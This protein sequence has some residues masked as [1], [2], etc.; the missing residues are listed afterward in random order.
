MAGF[1]GQVFR[2]T[3]EMAKVFGKKDIVYSTRKEQL[4]VSKLL[5]QKIKLATQLGAE[6]TAEQLRQ[7][8][9]ELRELVDRNDAVD[10]AALLVEAE[11]IH[12]DVAEFVRKYT[13]R[14]DGGTVVGP[15]A[16]KSIARILS[17]KMNELAPVGETYI[18]FWKR[19]GQTYALKTKKTRIPWVTYDKKKLWQDYRP[20]VQQEIRFYDPKS[21]RY[22]RNVYQMDTPDGKVY[23][24]ADIGDTRRGLG[25]NG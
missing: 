10:G 6:D 15:E 19:V 4:A 12:P 1:Q 18:D 3:E 23:G 9:L 20:K 25:V 13:S 8:K 16:F 14:V 5:D 24:K 2:V 21:R 7:F 11:E 17:E 22:V